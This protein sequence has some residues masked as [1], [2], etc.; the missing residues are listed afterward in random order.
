MYSGWIF[1]IS[2]TIFCIYAFY[3][4]LSLN[5]CCWGCSSKWEG[6]EGGGAP[7]P[8][9]WQ[10]SGQYNRR[11]QTTRLK[12]F[13]RDHFTRI[14]CLFLLKRTSKHYSGKTAIIGR[15]NVR[16]FDEMVE[17]VCLVPENNRPQVHPNQKSLYMFFFY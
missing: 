2:I 6:G 13:L 7:Y 9:W 17:L 4:M 16:L 1:Y 14:Y 11:Q 15:T 10:N 12:G 3:H 5:I 8:R